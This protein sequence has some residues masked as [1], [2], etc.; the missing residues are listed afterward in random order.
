[1]LL[2]SYLIFLQPIGVSWIDVIKITNGI[3]EYIA[4][5]VWPPSSCTSSLNYP[6]DPLGFNTLTTQSA[7]VYIVPANM[8]YAY[9]LAANCTLVLHSIDRIAELLIHFGTCGKYIL[10]RARLTGPFVLLSWC[11][12]MAWLAWTQLLIKCIAYEHKDG[13]GYQSGTDARFLCVFTQLIVSRF[14]LLP[15]S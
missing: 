3:I 15:P 14:S 2:W 4:S 12:L 11:H 8:L 5:Y 1:M 7:L 13:Q 6:V 9:M 10:S